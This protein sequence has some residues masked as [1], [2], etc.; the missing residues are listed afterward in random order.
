MHSAK[1]FRDL[2]PRLRIMLPSGKHK[3]MSYL[4]W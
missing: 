2:K 4:W 3:E 1:M